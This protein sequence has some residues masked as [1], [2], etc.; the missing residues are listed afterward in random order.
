MTQNSSQLYNWIPYQ[1]INID[2]ETLCQWLY[3]G[4]EEFSEPFF[5]ETIAKC[6]KLPFNCYPQKGVSNISI[7][8]EWAEGIRIAEPAAFIFHVSR[9]GS[10]IISQLLSKSKAHIVLSEVPFFDDVL[11]LPYKKE[12]NVTGEEDLLKTVIRFYSQKRTASAQK[13]F[14]KTDSWHIFFHRRIRELFPGVPFILLYRKPDEVIRSIR[15][16]P[17]MQSVPGMIE[18][19]I[20]GFDNKVETSDEFYNYSIKVIEKF[21]EAYIEV[22]ENDNNFLLVNYNEGILPVMKKICEITDTTFSEMEWKTMEERIIYHGKYPGQFF[23]PEPE[24]TKIPDN[25]ANAF[26]LYNTLEQLRTS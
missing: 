21:M 15:K 8:K 2:N 13:V 10:T 19:E 22:A 16:K 1:F 9:C 18:S 25:L 11:R 4:T 12:L 7:L 20:L 3:L 17:G 24:E 23:L 6:K 26:G 5:N 14:I